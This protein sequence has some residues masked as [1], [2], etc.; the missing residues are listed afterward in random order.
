MKA[1][2]IFLAFFILFTAAAIAVPIPLFP[3]NIIPTLSS[4]PASEFTVYLEAL[5]N[6][7]TYGTIICIIFLLVDK[8]L[9]K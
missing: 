3:G 1:P 9:E 6:G 8:K 4:I 2:P 5:T 7:L